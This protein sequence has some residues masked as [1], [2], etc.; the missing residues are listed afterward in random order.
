MYVYAYSCVCVC[1]EYKFS[2]ATSFYD[3]TTVLGLIVILNTVLSKNNHKFTGPGVP[4]PL[5]DQPCVRSSSSSMIEERDDVQRTVDDASSVSGASSV[6][7]G[8]VASS[9]CSSELRALQSRIEDHPHYDLVDSL[10]SVSPDM[11][12]NSWILPS[13][14]RHAHLMER[15]L[16]HGRS[17]GQC[18]V[19]RSFNIYMRVSTGHTA[20]AERQNLRLTL[21]TYVFCMHH[22]QHNVYDTVK[23]NPQCMREPGEVCIN[24]NHMHVSQISRRRELR[25]SDEHVRSTAV[26]QKATADASAV[27]PTAV[28]HDSLKMDMAHTLLGVSEKR[29]RDQ[30]IAAH[31]SG[32]SARDV[33]RCM[34]LRMCRTPASVPV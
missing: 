31:Q 12:P 21:Q 18:F 22:P 20:C 7:W 8:S 3:T 6:Q 27:V 16:K 9:N 15:I 29:L 19:L 26:G 17:V 34:L 13:D 5:L 30:L 11:P 14:S 25:P 23:N 28:D 1:I 24:C 33:L 2:I 10:L 32:A 4:S